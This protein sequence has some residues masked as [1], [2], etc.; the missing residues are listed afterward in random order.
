MVS[1]GSTIGFSELASSL[2]FSTST[3]C[4]LRHLIQVEIVGDDLAL[5]DLGQFDQ[6]Q[7]NFPNRRKIIFHDLNLEIAAFSAGAA[8]CPARG[9][10]DCASA[11]PPS[12]RPVAIPA[13]RT[14]A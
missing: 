6:L 2:M 9:V 11:N 14:A 1:P 7:I 4:K 8:E 3:P 12:R 10:H 5:V 13:A